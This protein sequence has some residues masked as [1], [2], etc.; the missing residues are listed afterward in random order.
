M[1]QVTENIGAQIPGFVGQCSELDEFVAHDAGRG[2]H[3]LQIGIRKITHDF[4]GKLFFHVNVMVLYVQTGG[5]VR[6]VGD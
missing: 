1:S 3:S 5:D 2:G 6:R 4:G